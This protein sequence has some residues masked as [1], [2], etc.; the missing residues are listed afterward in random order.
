MVTYTAPNAHI[1]SLFSYTTFKKKK[2]R[3]RPYQRRVKSQ[4]LCDAPAVALAGLDALA[5]SPQLHRIGGNDVQVYYRLNLYLSDKKEETDVLGLRKDS[6]PRCFGYAAA[7][8]AE[9]ADGRGIRFREKH[10]AHMLTSTESRC[11]TA[12]QRT[13]EAVLKHQLR[14]SL[15][16]RCAAS[17]GEK[18]AAEKEA[19]ELGIRLDVETQLNRLKSFIPWSAGGIYQSFLTDFLHVFGVNTFF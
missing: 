1:C 17:R 8:A 9:R 3:L 5:S 13:P 6:C 7:I 16:I 11:P 14:L 12:A 4:V 10:F 2:E 19:R 18:E 15:A